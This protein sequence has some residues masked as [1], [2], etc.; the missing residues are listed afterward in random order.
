MANLQG[1]ALLQ[2]RIEPDEVTLAESLAYPSP[3]ADPDI[4]DVVHAVTGP[5]SAIVVTDR[6]VLWLGGKEER[7]IRELL[8]PMVTSYT[9]VTHAHRYALLFE[10]RQVERHQWVPAHRFLMWSWGNAEAILSVS[11]SFLAFSRRDTAAA[12]AIR[13]Q[14]QRHGIPAREPLTLPNAL[15][16]QRVRPLR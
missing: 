15:R 4:G 3:H 8:Y 14:L 2:A 16:S 7:W 11:R 12:R 10:H 6:R 5:G 1:V 9:E 13:E